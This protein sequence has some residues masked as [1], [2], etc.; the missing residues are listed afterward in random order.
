MATE[1]IIERCTALYEDLEF[2]AAR[3]WKAAEPGRKVVGYMPVYVPEEI[4]H[5]AGMMPLGIVGGGDQVEDD[6][7]GHVRAVLR[8]A[9]EL[10]GRGRR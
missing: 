1:D 9:A 10:R 7:P 6:A 8:R 2:S 3:E 5:A 4:I